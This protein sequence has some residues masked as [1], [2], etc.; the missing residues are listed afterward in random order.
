[1]GQPAASE[2]GLQAGQGHTGADGDLGGQAV[3]RVEAVEAPQVHDHLAVDGDRAADE[4]R[5]AALRDEG[6][7]RVAGSTDHRGHLVGGA[8]PQDRPGPA[9]P[10]A[11][12]VHALAGHHVGI[13]EHVARPERLAAPVQERRDHAGSSATRRSV[14]STPVTLSGTRSPSGRA[15]PSTVASTA[16]S[17]GTT[18]DRSSPTATTVPGTTA[19]TCGSSSSATTRSTAARLAPLS[20]PLA[21]ANARGSSVSAARTWSGT[22]EPAW[23]ARHT[24]SAARSQRRRSGAVTCA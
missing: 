7:A 3:H 15:T 11:G 13:G 9:L 19:P 12:P 21:R 20:R 24:S 10:P 5:V 4:A 23:R 18:E 6:D 17:P 2:V 16:R 22:F 1:E 8:G 14:T